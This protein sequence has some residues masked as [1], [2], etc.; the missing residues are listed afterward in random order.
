MFLP[1]SIQSV[2]DPDQLP[3]GEYDA[4][5]LVWSSPDGGERLME[6]RYTPVGQER[7]KAC[8]LLFIDASGNMRF[9]DFLRM[10]D[11]AWRDSFGARADQLTSLLPDAVSTYRLVDEQDLGSLYLQE[12][13]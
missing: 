9:C 12:S 10:P 7:P 8:D 5:C 6:Y 3:R 13:A 4:T 11:D 2:N 1:I